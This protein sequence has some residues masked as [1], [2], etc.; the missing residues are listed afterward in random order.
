MSR[1]TNQTLR[2]RTEYLCD[3]ANNFEE[4]FSIGCELED[5]GRLIK[6]M[7]FQMRDLQDKV[8]GQAEH[9][10]ALLKKGGRE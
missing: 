4:N 8:D 6:L 5:I 3:K 7:A 2:N 10:K 1:L 9:I